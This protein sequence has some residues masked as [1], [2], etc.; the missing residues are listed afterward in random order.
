MSLMERTVLLLGEGG[1]EKL[2]NAHVIVF[3][4]G[5]V[6]GYAAEALA[7]AGIGRLTL[8]DADTVADSN[9]NRQL[10]A[11]CS[12][13]GLPKVEVAAARIRDIN[14]ACRVRTV[15]R[16]YL[17]DASEEPDFSDADYIV[18]AIDTVTAKLEI[19]RRA[20]AAGV[21]VISCMGTGNRLHP[22]LLRLTTLDRTEGCPLARVMRVECRHRGLSPE[23]LPVVYSAEPARKCTVPD[24]EGTGRHAPGS[25]SFVPGV[26]GLMMAGRV[27][28]D[29][30][31]IE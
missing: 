31:G 21:R 17:P 8:V 15:Q 20:R 18:D 23:T 2:E 4:L 24:T 3:G 5:G 11:L 14:P 22:E 25:I 16:F 26:A 29:L 19:L 6:G 9:R 13:V 30:A 12:T 1:A 7:R 10:L 28:R 27:I